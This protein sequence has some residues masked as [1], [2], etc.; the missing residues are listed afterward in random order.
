M[1]GVD[2]YGRNLAETLNRLDQDTRQRILDAAQAIIGLPAN[3][4]PRLSKD[5]GRFYFVQHEPKLHYHVHQTG[6][7][8]GTM[9]VLALMTALRASVEPKLIGIEAPENHLHPDAL[10]SLI[11]H[12]GDVGENLQL[13]FTTHSPHVLDVLRDPAAVRVV[14]RD[15]ARGTV[16][17]S[18]DADAVSRALAASGFGLGEYHQT[19]GFGN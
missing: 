8:S 16:V 19:R 5:E 3:I 6:I 7:S 10:S 9:R 11:E 13:L 14:R 4:Q 18:G 12:I 17:E 1:R 15:E 2:R